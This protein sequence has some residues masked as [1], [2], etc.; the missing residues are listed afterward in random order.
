M[1]IYPMGYSGWR[2]EDVAAK[3]EELNALVVDV[4]LHAAG[5][6]ATASRAKATV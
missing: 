5:S 1:K 6:R 4:R 2:P 3:A